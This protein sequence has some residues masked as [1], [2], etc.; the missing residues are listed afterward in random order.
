MNRTPR[1]RE[2]LVWVTANDSAVDHSMTSADLAVGI[3]IPGADVLALCGCRFSLA[4][5]VADPGEPCQRCLQI[6]SAHGSCP[7]WLESE[8]AQTPATSAGPTP[9]AAPG[10]VGGLSSWRDSGAAC[11]PRA[12]S[13]ESR[14]GPAP[15]V[16]ERCA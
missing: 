16:G 1:T 4:P 8:L 2:R 9:G 3:G 7:A 12:R 14:H 11:S 6:A 5:I 15:V 10:Q 13:S